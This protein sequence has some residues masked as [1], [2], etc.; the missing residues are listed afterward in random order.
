[1]ILIEG[2]KDLFVILWNG[3]SEFQNY[4]HKIFQRILYKRCIYIFDKIASVICKWEKSYDWMNFYL[5]YFFKYEHFIVINKIKILIFF[6]RI[7]IE[8]DR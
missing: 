4:F 3:I 6:Q 5:E 2:I 7:W 1:M 8:F